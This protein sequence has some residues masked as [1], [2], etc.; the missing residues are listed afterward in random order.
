MLACL[1]WFN[2]IP[3][4]MMWLTTSLCQWDILSHGPNSQMHGFGATFNIEH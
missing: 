3:A 4:G 1:I 2:G